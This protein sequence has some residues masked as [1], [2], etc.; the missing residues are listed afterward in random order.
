MQERAPGAAGDGTIASQ[1]SLSVVVLRHREQSSTDA[2]QSLGNVFNQ[3][4]ML[5]ALGMPP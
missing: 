3:S 5:R 2:T 4:A 1:R